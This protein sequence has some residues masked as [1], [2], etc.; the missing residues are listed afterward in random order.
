MRHECCYHNC[1][2]GGVVHIGTNGGDSHW[3]CF[4]HIEKW[5]TDRDRFLGDGG[6]FSLI[7]Y[8]RVK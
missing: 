8:V 2:R 4:R 1:L 3:I 6:G 5:N 7:L